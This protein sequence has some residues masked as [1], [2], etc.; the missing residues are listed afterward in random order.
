MFQ[1]LCKAQRDWDELV[2]TELNQ[3]WLSTLSDLRPGG[4]VS[5]KRCHA[6][7]LGRN[8][9][10]SLQLHCFADASEK[11]YRAVVYMRV[12][13]ESRV[14]CEIVTSKTRVTLLNKKTIPRLELLSNL[15][16]STLV[17]SVSQ[18]LETVVK[19]NV[20]NWTDS[21]IS[22]WWIRNTEEEYLTELR[23]HHNCNS[24]N[25]K[26]AIKVGDVICV[27]KNKAPR[28]LCGMGVV[29]SL[30][31]GRDGYHRGAVVRVRS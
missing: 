18:P 27:Y 5:L 23:V 29:K 17:N 9:V 1:K 16:A 22:L 8:E 2:D 6:E 30:I 15:T 7:G 19:V 13:Y 26:L 14:E 21:M 31:T 20:V 28:Q 24:S 11:A 25:R 3:E 4:R 12:E 10:K